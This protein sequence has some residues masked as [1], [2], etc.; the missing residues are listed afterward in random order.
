MADIIRLNLSLE[1]YLD[2]LPIC[3]WVVFKLLSCK[4]SLYILDTR[5][6]WGIEFANIFSF[7]GFSF[8]FLDSILQ[9]IKFLLF[10][11]CDLTIFPFLAYAFGIVFK[12]PLPNPKSWR[13]TY[14]SQMELWRNWIY[15]AKV[16]VSLKPIKEKKK[17]TAKYTLNYLKK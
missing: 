17:K 13:F 11:K 6:F 2:P 1:K 7:C 14:V 8:H 5:L 3:N 15:V 9:C 4:N 16:N 12:K 10:V